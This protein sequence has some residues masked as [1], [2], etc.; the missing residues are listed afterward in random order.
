MSKQTYTIG[1]VDSFPPGTRLR[2]EIGR[3][4]IAVFN[5]DGRFYAIHDRCPHQFAPLSRGKIQGTLVCSADTNWEP[6]W[7]CEGEI[8]VC[9]GHGMEYHV[10]TGQA[11]G[12]NFRLRTYTIFV[13]DG[14]VKL[15]A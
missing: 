4:V 8:V 2:V 14:E 3:K 13:E 6:E 11:I 10:K 9:P 7:T 1:Q 12:Y 5:I 15:L